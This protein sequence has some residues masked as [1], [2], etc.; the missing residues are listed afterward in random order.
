M[1]SEIQPRD[2]NIHYLRT[3]QSKLGHIFSNL[4]IQASQTVAALVLQTYD[5][6]FVTGKLDAQG[7]KIGIIVSRFK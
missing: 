2:N 1:P 3:K 7:I 5:G 4:E 6:R